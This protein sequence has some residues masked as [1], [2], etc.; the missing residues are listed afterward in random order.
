MEVS[1]RKLR[2]RLSEYLRRAQAGEEVVITSR[3]KPVARLLG[4]NRSATNA[5]TPFLE[6]LRLASWIRPTQRTDGESVELP[7]SLP[8]PDGMNLGEAVM[9][10]RR[11]ARR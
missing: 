1:A 3:G 9:A 6:R 11:D 5:E 10:D 7:E 4:L 8:L 2:S